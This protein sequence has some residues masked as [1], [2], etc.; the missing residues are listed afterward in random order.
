[1]CL[2]LDS[3]NS[4]S[5]GKIHFHCSHLALVSICFNSRSAG[6]IHWAAIDRHARRAGVSIPAVRVRYIYIG[7]EM[8]DANG[9]SIPAVRVRYIETYVVMEATKV[10]SIPAVRVRYIFGHGVFV[11]V[12][13]RFNSR[14]AGKIHCKKDPNLMADA[15][16]FNSRSAGKIHFPYFNSK[17]QIVGVSIPAVRVR[18]ISKNNEN[19][20]KNLQYNLCNFLSLLFY[21]SES[22]KL[23]LPFAQKS[24]KIFPVF[25]FSPVRGP[26]L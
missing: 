12:L 5:A 18:Y 2:I 9:V 25:I 15:I 26:V 17:G 7:P 4:R 13:G 16:C 22:L 24:K 14:S 11:T 23:C 10:V 21:Y 8:E 20:Q 3:F 1:M 19:A 6:K